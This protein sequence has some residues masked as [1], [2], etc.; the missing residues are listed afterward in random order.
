LLFYCV[1][2]L[3]CFIVASCA[4]KA[5]DD[6]GYIIIKRYDAIHAVRDFA[7]SILGT[8]LTHYY[9]TT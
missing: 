5:A 2:L 7:V 9:G 4:L 3:F 1:L 6:D 8:F